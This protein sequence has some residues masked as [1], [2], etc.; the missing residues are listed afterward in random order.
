MIPT[1]T[2]SYNM[3]FTHS[4]EAIAA[5]F[6]LTDTI[7]SELTGLQITASP[8][9]VLDQLPGQPYVWEVDNSVGLASGTITVT[10]TIIEGL[11]AGTI[12]SNEVSMY[13]PVDLNSA[14]D[15]AE[16]DVTVLNAAPV[17]A[18]IG[19][20][21]IY[22]GETLTFTASASDLN[23]DDLTFSLDS[24]PDGAVIHPTSGVFNWEPHQSQTDQ[25]YLFSI[26]VNDGEVHD[27]ETITVT[28]GYK[29]FL[30]LLEK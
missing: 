27:C 28:V 11:A 14:N 15:F 1:G 9:L 22:A 19:N 4:E 3:V 17:L 12:I 13:N 8:G 30:P 7:P 24:E 23:W 18:P 16:T 29:L 21:F 20:Q 10:G 2:I 5:S 26:C 6:I 25:S